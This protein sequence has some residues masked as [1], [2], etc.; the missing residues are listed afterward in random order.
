MNCYDLYGYYGWYNYFVKIIPIWFPARAKTGFD[1]PGSNVRYDSGGETELDINVERY[2][3]I[4]LD[5]LKI[6]LVNQF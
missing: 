1:E 2:T 3:I 4:K 6:L 5:R